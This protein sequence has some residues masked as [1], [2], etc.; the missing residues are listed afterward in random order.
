MGA[1]P[2]VRA[3][4]GGDVELRDCRGSESLEE[5]AHGLGGGKLATDGGR[6]EDYGGGHRGGN[7]G[8]S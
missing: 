1:G 3:V 6:T 7:S 2:L 4:A 5:G 8:S